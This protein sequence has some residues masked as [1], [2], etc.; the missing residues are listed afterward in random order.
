VLVARDGRWPCASN[1]VGEPHGLEASVARRPATAL[2]RASV[3]PADRSLVFADPRWVL[4][5][6]P[7]ARAARLGTGPTVAIPLGPPVAQPDAVQHA[8]AREPVRG[9]SVLLAPLRR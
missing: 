9:G 7:P 1:R 2:D 4:T 8:V 5:R 3:R 6:H